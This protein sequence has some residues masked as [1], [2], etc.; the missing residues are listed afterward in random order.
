[1]RYLAR[2][3]LILVLL[4][5]MEVSSISQGRGG[6][7]PIPGPPPPTAATPTP[8][9]TPG[10]PPA[11]TRVDSAPAQRTVTINLKGGYPVTGK[12]IR[13]SANMIQLEISGNP[14]SM[15]I[16]DVESM[17]FA[18]ASETREAPT[19]QPTPYPSQTSDS[20]QQSEPVEAADAADSGHIFD[21]PATSAPALNV[22]DTS[23]PDIDA[24]DIDAHDPPAPANGSP[25]R[26]A[27]PTSEVATNVVNALRRLP[28]ADGAI[29]ARYQEYGARV[30]EVK[31]EVEKSLPALPDGEF[32]NE[33]RLALKAYTDARRAW[34]S[35]IRSNKRHPSMY[36]DSDILAA[37]LQKTY[38]IPT[39]TLP[40]LGS[41]DDRGYIPTF[42][43][44]NLDDILSTIWGTAREHTERA[45]ALQR[46]EK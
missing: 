13:A 24:P 38:K 19:P 5:L 12:F 42:R 11:E 18:P 39:E 40:G 36:P 2:T 21:A 44:M 17:L 10:T 28:A 27:A 45:S 43:A 16:D 8:E 30:T 32:K 41:P 25:P 15:S 33:V 7:A 29:G 34:D 35:I 9:P 14:I 26:D 37:I 6:R 20:G 4:G 23:A 3:A 22:P 1:M 31:A 46:N